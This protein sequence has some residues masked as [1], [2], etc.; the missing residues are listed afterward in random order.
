M[1]KEEG[2]SKSGN[3]QHLENT[4][5]LYYSCNFSKS[6]IISEEKVKIKK[7]RIYHMIWDKHTY[8]NS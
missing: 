3:S 8:I 1:G 4:G 7:E 5:A 2:N 6:E